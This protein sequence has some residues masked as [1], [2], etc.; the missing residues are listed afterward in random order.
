MWALKHAEQVS[1]I[2]IMVFLEQKGRSVTGLWLYHIFKLLILLFGFI[3]M[4][5]TAIFLLSF[6]T[7]YIDWK[8]QA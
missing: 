4:F 1:W 3:M 5:D 6:D 7:D 2:G 8:H